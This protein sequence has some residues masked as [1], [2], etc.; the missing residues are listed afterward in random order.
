MK[1]KIVSLMLVGTMVLSALTGCGQSAEKPEKTESVATKETEAASEATKESVSE[2]PQKVGVT[3]PLEEKVTL[4]IGLEKSSNV[5]AICESHGD[6]PFFKALEEQVG[7]ELEFVEVEG[8]DVNL[9]FSGATMP[10]IIAFTDIT[11]KYPGGFSALLE[12]NVIVP[13]TEYLDECAPDYKAQLE[14]F[15]VESRVAYVGDEVG[16]FLNYGADMFIATN[17]MVIRQDWLDDLGLQVPTSAD[18]L[19]TV[20]KAFKEK[21]GA[22]VPL[23]PWSAYA[24]AGLLDSGNITSSFGL[25]NTKYYL[26]DG[27][28][29]AGF[30]QDEC[31]DVL[32][33]MHKLY[34]EGLLDPNYPANDNAM[35]M[36]NL[37]SGASGMAF[38]TISSGLTPVLDSMAS[39]PT[40]KLTGMAPF[41]T[42]D[43]DISMYAT[44][45]SITSPRA[46]ITSDCENVEA[47]VKLLNYG[48]SEA[49]KMLYNFGIE[50]ESY[51]MVNGVP[52]YTEKV[53][54]NPDM[55]KTQAAWQYTRVLVGG[56]KIQMNEYLTSYNPGEAQKGALEAWNTSNAVDYFIPKLSMDGDMA[57]EYSALTADLD[58]Y[59]AEMFTKFIDGTESL[60]NWDAFV[61]QCK[62]LKVDRIIEIQQHYYDEQYK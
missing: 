49:G 13:I 8:T 36:A 23:S 42:P 28:I 2:E 58:T 26:K 59:R 19:Y 48:Y 40:F 20:L 17:G 39:D 46:F 10:D 6:T 47:A 1:K 7:V 56:P 61:K 34:D 32:E 38:L 52:Q 14:K 18:E 33:Y 12:D 55:S 44:Y 22:T 35:Q 62:A 53:F 54:N 29:E 60:D 43:G 11:A 57:Q 45:N 15:P 4:T 30:L 21:K 16:A 27:K 37:T 50:G 51:E 25:V 3:Y 5:L 41:K 31:R 24:I 9:L